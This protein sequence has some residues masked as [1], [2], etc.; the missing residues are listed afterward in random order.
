MRFQARTLDTATSVFTA[1]LVAID[2]KIA[3]LRTSAHLIR[4]PVRDTLR[5]R[6]STWSLGAR[7][8]FVVASWGGLP[9][10]K[11][12][13]TPDTISPLGE[14]SR[15]WSETRTYARCRR[16]LLA[17][18]R[19]RPLRTQ[20][21]SNECRDRLSRRVPPADAERVA[22]RVGVHLV[23]LFG[24]EIAWLEQPGAEPHR[25]FVCSSRVFDVEVEMHLLRNPIR[26]FG[27]N[28]GSAP[29]ARRRAT[30]R[31]H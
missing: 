23:A 31:R 12:T 11:L 17:P 25:H 5:R 21:I 29:V 27:R 24:V 19:V 1:P 8:V 13:G 6:W 18:S 3:R 7:K 9:K 26:P 28:R 16:L 4:D 10:R 20:P 22:C 15:R 14:S 2:S 30:R